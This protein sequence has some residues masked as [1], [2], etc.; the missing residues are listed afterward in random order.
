MSLSPR[1]LE[2]LA[3]PVDKGPLVY[4]AAEH[5]L[6]NPR[7]HLRYT[8]Q[9]DVP[10]LLPDAGQKVS[11]PDHLALMARAESLGVWPTPAK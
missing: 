9:N 6:Y 1:L 11:E 7:L 10:N 8:V 4:L 5:T 2:V 3:C